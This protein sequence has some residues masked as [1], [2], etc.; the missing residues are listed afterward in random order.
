V[1]PA[2]NL[3]DVVRGLCDDTLWLRAV[4]AP[5]A[6]RENCDAGRLDLAKVGGNLTARRAMEVAAAGGHHLFLLNNGSATMLAER[7]PGILPPLD[8]QAGREIADVISLTGQL[9]RAPGAQPPLSAP[10]YSAAPS[11]VFGSAIAN[12]PGAVSLA[13]RGVL[14]LADAPEFP[15]L[16]LNGL[17]QPMANGE[18]VLSKLGRTV[19]FPARFLLVMDARPCPCAGDQTCACTPW[20][21]RRY[22]A[23]LTGLLSRIAVRATTEPLSHSAEA[24]EST[25]AVAERVREARDRAQFRLSGT[26]WTTNA[27]VP[28]LDLRTAYPAQPEAVD[29]LRTAVNTGSLI[30]EMLPEL[31][32]VAWTLA[33]LRGADRPTTADAASALALWKDGHES[34]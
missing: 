19:R 23:R 16:I 29:L 4:P 28:T 18:V 14:H 3:A 33:D 13:H 6:Q 2:G 7:L 31:L 32:R 25:A 21:K 8:P 11:A 17:L 26:P 15:E 12:R 1:I 24:G 20:V 5:T 10:H 22:R 9:D 34:R 30:S 27:E